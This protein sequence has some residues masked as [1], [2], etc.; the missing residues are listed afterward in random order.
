MVR[1]GAADHR[2]G[3]PPLASSTD[4]IGAGQR[5]HRTTE[6]SGQATVWTIVKIDTKS[7][8][9]W[10]AKKPRSVTWALLPRLDSNQEPSG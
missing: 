10:V 2:D 6:A 5:R 9:P 4:D 1:Y 8:Y 7:P 3:R